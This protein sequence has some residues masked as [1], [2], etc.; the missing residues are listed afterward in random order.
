MRDH[1]YGVA[2][3]HGT[4]PD[5]PDPCIQSALSWLDRRR[6]IPQPPRHL[7][8]RHRRQVGHLAHVP[9]GYNPNSNIDVRDLRRDRNRQLPAAAKEGRLWTYLN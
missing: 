9:A 6:G 8:H 4:V 1:L 5:S 3:I 7:Y 2:A